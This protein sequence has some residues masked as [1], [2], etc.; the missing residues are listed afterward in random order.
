MGLSLGQAVG[1]H[2]MK[3]AKRWPPSLLAVTQ[4]GEEILQMDSISQQAV[5]WIKQRIQMVEI[6][7]MN[8]TLWEHAT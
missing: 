1:A 8:G 6:S 7:W 3:G 2:S 5:K 4:L